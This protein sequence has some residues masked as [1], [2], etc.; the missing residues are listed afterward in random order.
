MSETCHHCGLPLPAKSVVGDGAGDTDLQ[1]CCPGC[2]LAHDLIAGL[3]LGKYYALRELDASV[4][5]LKPDDSQADLDLAFY[6]RPGGGEGENSEISL[7]VEGYQCAACGWLIEQVLGR[8][9]RVLEARVNMT[10]HRLRVVWRGDT[11]LAGDILGPVLKLGYRLF[12]FDADLVEENRARRDRE[13]LK[14]MA[15]AGFAAANVMLLSVSVWAGYSQGMGPATRGLLHWVSAL[16]ALPAVVY[17]GR[18]F[19]RSCLTALAAGRVNMDVPISLAVVLTS[20]MSLFQTISGAQ[21]V[22]FDSAVGLLFFLLIGRYLDSRARSRAR[23]SAAHLLTLASK[24]VSVLSAD[25]SRRSLPPDRVEV[26]M[27][28]AVAAGERIGVDGR[29]GKGR[30]EIDQ[31]LLSGESLPVAVM[32]GDMVN[33]GTLN[34]GQPLQIIATATGEATALAEIVR[35]ME[36][37]EQGRARFVDLAERIARLYAPVVHGLGA[38]TFIGWLALGAG[39]QTALLNAVAVLIITCPCALALAVPA[40]QVAAASRLMRRGVLLKTATALERLALA[41]TVVFDKT[42]TLTTGALALSS[43]PP[44]TALSLAAGLAVN[45]R[46]PLSQALVRAATAQGLEI[47]GV[48]AVAETPGRGLSGTA[49]GVEVRLGS[50]AHCAV[51][52]NA[53]AGPELWLRRGDEPAQHFS[54]EDQLRADAADVVAELKKLGYEVKLLSGDQAETVAAVARTLAIE[55]HRGIADPAEKHRTLGNLEAAGHR[56]LM[57]GDGLN[58]APSLAA[59]FVSLSPSTAADISQT[60]SD[61]VFQGARLAPV[62]ETLITARRARSVIRQNLAFAFLYNA[63]TIPFAVAGLVTPLFA[64]LAMS[65]SSIIVIGN[66]LRLGLRRQSVG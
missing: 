6:A 2:A 49:A 64:A 61:A 29:V 58:D 22:Y 23:A 1:F 66:A 46:H 18:P 47:A 37:A 9:A 11:E 43:E 48:E 57:V 24:N 26:G 56:V 14:A 65:A 30:S 51:D 39:W 38:L 45:S 32:P 19:F 8:D 60:A 17:A 5:A 15:V 21:H 7:V 31:S 28:V 34:I 44:S 35:L 16:I 50:R 10:T 3:G 4:R 52:G 62:L 33:A 20:A 36:Q 13:L 42:G 63:T 41:D 40:V 59:A 55:D 54:F 27:T 25:G 53:A 12:P